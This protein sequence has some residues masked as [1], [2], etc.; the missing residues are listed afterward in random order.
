MTA[1]ERLTFRRVPLAGPQGEGQD[2][3]SILSPGL[4]HWYQRH[5]SMTWAQRLKRVFKLDI[6]VCDHYGALSR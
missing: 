2:A 1:G 5:M 6:E 4:P 3:R